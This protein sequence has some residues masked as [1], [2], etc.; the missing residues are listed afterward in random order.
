M[1]ITNGG[2]YVHASKCFCFYW[3][4]IVFYFGKKRRKFGE[5]EDKNGASGGV[6]T[7]FFKFSVPFLV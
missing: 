6:E 5:V 3:I 4:S 2:A 7:T 1:H